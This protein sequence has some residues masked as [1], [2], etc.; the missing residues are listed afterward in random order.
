[1]SR[2]K[3]QLLLALVGVLVVFVALM[4]N[5]LDPLR[6]K[7]QPGK[8]ANLELGAE[9][10]SATL[11]GLKEVVAGLLWVRTDEFFH[12]GNY[13]AVMPMVR[14]ITWLDPHQIDVY[15]TGAWHLSYNFT[16]SQER[17]D[18]R[19]I[20]ASRALLREGIINNPSTYDLYFSLGWLNFNK[21]QDYKQSI[22]WLSQANTK[23]AVDAATGKKMDRPEYVGHELAHRAGTQWTARARNRA[24]EE[25]PGCERGIRPEIL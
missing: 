5:N 10:V 23:E 1:M 11:I 19:Y 13:E 2:T 12:T 20:P 16:D 18:R 25:E 15:D 17:S 22:I 7:Y 8:V 14:I 21:M 4:Q 3:K 9:F 6:R 24:V